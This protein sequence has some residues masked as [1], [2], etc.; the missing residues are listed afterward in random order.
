[1]S[2]PS[3]A[4]Q[5]AIEAALRGSAAL[6]TAMGGQI[7]LYVLA[8][9]TNAPF[10]YLTLGEDQVIGDETECSAGSEVATTIHVWARLDEDVSGTRAQAKSIAGAVRGAITD[11]LAVTGFDVVDCTFEQTRHLIDPDRRTA[12]SVVQHRLLVEPV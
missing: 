8:P 6:A 5:T 4:V 3:V 12:H 1:M 7:R 9:P 10:P 2:D 11:A